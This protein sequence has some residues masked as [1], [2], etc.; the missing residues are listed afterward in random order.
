[1]KSI[2]MIPIGLAALAAILFSGLPASAETPPD[3]AGLSKPQAGDMQMI[4]HGGTGPFQV[5][6]RLSLDPNAPWYDITEAKVTAVNTGVYLAVFPLNDKEDVAFYRV[7]SVG[8]TIVELKG[9]SIALRVSAPANGLYFAAGEAPVVT[10]TLLDT[11]AQGLDRADFSSLNLYLYGPQDPLKT[12]T[13]SKLLNASTNRAARP[14][15]YIDLKTNPNVGVTNN[16]L[17]YRLQ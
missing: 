5:Q 6:K 13:A 4:F 11:F 14:H 8:E 10:V 7:M 17:T 2:R 12:V 15:H 3:I 16:V 9:W 1:M